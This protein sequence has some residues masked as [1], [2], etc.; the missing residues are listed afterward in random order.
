[1]D[2]LLL[3]FSV[4]SIL[5]LPGSTTSSSEFIVQDFAVIMIVAAIML[6]ITHKLKQSMVIGYLIAGMIIGP[7]TPPF[8]LIN[9][10]ETVNIFAE[11]GIIML[12][13]VIGIE[14][15]IAKLKQIG[16]ISMMVG[17]TES[18]GTLI[19]TF[20][21]AQRLGFTIFDS[22]FLGLAMSITSTV[23]TIKVLEELGRIKERTSMLI[24][25]ILI[26]E[27]IVAVSALAILQSI[28][29]A[30]TNTEEI[31]I[32]PISISIAIA[33]VFIGSILILGSKFLPNM[34]DKIGKTNDYALL[35]I[36][37]LGLAFGLSFIA[38]MLGL[39]V[40]IGA[41]LAGVLVAESR[42]ATVA[43]VITIPLRDVFSALFFVSI[44]ALVN[45]ALIP[46][47]I[48]PVIILILTA[49]TVKLILVLAIL[50][51]SKFDY[52][53]RL[54]VG[55]GLA[56]AKGEMSL[57]IAKGGQDVGAITSSI[58]PILSVVTIITSFATPYVLKFAN[59]IRF[60]SSSNKV[61]K[62]IDDEN[63]DKSK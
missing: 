43:K 32:F 36:V 18:I 12:L 34:I 16:K 51:K 57:V 1:M 60:S 35:L 8:T 44:G 39:S 11:L 5:S 31:A 47:Y 24:L 37:I 63:E 62:K 30:A 13:F 52:T 27:D 3:L 41:F 10:I 7:Y 21:V 56:T 53:E 19:I 58:L 48:V 25:G 14:F 23:V 29:V 20:F 4:F 40:V 28:A 55:L 26:V 50:S 15:P 42:T 2:I 38:N 45:V 17:L 46:L 54:K 59:N 61:N 6:F 33:V 9:E 49:F 22:M